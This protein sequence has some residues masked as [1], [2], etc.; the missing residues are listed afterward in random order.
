MITFSSTSL[1][2]RLPRLET[3]S[4]YL[5]LH[6]FPP[7]EHEAQWRDF[8][9]RVET[10]SHYNAP[11]FFLEPWWEEKRPFA[12]L[13]L[14]R[15]K[16]TGIL[17]GVHESVQVHCG[18]LS[19][20]QIC[21][22]PSP[23]EGMTVDA[24]ARG[25][26]AEARSAKLI[27][28]YSWTPFQSF[29]RYGFQVRPMEGAVI[30]DLTRGPDM[31]MKQFHP[32][33]RRNIRFAIQKGLEVSL[34]S[35]EKDCEEVYDLYCEWRRTRRKKILGEQVSFSTFKKSWSLF[36]NRRIFLVRWQGKLVASDSVRFF[37]GGLVEAAGNFSLEKFLYL[38]P[39]DLVIWRIIEWACK[40]GFTRLSLGGAHSFL[41]YFGGEIMP[42]YRYR[43]DRTWLRRHHLHEAVLDVGRATLGKMP[44]PIERMVRWLLR[45]DK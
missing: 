16:V 6:A 8:L 28:L 18:Q 13:A 26:L 27:E 32:N 33:R 7:P 25:L 2:P 10:P 3:K 15:E 37:P 17:T 31:L 1:E 43:F 21:I 44:V 40:E 11:E 22:E 5:I 23:G 41:R 30:L 45:K 9:S 20:P 34:L 19:R 39:N 35:S 4:N 42:T 12:V 38:K 36:G 24:L 29:E 14:E